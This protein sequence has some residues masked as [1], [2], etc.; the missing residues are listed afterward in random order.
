MFLAQNGNQSLAEQSDSYQSIRYF[1]EITAKPRLELSE[2]RMPL[3]SFPH[4]FAN[5]DNAN[6][7]QSA[8]AAIIAFSDQSPI[9]AQLFCLPQR[10][11]I[12]VLIQKERKRADRKAGQ[13]AVQL[14]V[15]TKDQR[16][17]LTDLS[18]GW[19]G[20][21]PKRKWKT[22]TIRVWKRFY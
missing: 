5:K 3:K 7:I 2:H 8:H 9:L 19:A 10:K 4:R 11:V 16:R 22:S 6:Q 14:T 17:T 21:C 1:I 13:K 15:N 20:L 12:A 18:F